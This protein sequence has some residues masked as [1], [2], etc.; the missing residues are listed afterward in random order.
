MSVYYI[1]H[2]VVLTCMFKTFGR[3]RLTTTIMP[4]I[5]QSD[6]GVC[7]LFTNLAAC[8]HTLQI[9]LHAFIL[10]K[11]GCMH[12]YF[13][14]S[15]ACICTSKWSILIPTG[16]VDSNEELQDNYALVIATISSVSLALDAMHGYIWGSEVYSKWAE[17]YPH[18]D[19][20]NVALFCPKVNV[21]PWMSL[22]A[23]SQEEKR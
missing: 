15:A 19:F 8:T 5:F 12:S 16:S 17:F 10:H 20:W 1:N 3:Y 13:T 2:P 4:F 11:F 21:P 9:W 14:N 23:F 18:Q 6:R 7:V 22:S